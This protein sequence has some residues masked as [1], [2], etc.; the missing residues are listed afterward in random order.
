MHSNAI[1]TPYHRRE[2]PVSKQG[3]LVNTGREEANG[4]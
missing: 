2:A 4:A 1:S 3:K